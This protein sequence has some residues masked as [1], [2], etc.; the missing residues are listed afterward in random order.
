MV[1]HCNSLVDC[2]SKSSLTL[3]LQTGRHNIP[4]KTSKESKRGSCKR[5]LSPS[6]SFFPNAAECPTRIDS[7]PQ[8]AP[9]ILECVWG[10]VGDR[11]HIHTGT[12][13]CKIINLDA[14]GVGA[15]LAHKSTTPRALVQTNWHT[16]LSTL[17]CTH[18]TSSGPDKHSLLLG[19]A[20]F[21]PPLSR[22][23]RAP[24]WRRGPSM[25]QHC[26][27]P[28][29]LF[30][31]MAALSSWLGWSSLYDA[32]SKPLAVYFC[33]ELIILHSGTFFTS[34]IRESITF[35]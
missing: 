32:D 3:F 35:F 34:P 30:L 13:V 27:L 14:A 10:P 20:L 23:H 25:S 16:N 2:V 4:Q 9:F 33:Q 19:W 29:S 1:C 12:C 22:T 15:V 11:I 24:G 7:N 26:P 6:L 5:S 8:W 18:S 17:T 21:S 28:R 31:G